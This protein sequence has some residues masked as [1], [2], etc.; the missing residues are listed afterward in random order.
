MRKKIWFW[1]AA[2]VFFSTASVICLLIMGSPPPDNV[3]AV[4]GRLAACPES[5]NC[6]CSQCDPRDRHF[7]KPL[8]LTEGPLDRQFRKLAKVVAELPRAIIVEQ[9]ETYLHAEFRSRLGF[10][11]DVEFLLNADD[12]L[13]HVRSASRTGWYDFG[14]NRK[15]IEQ[16]RRKWQ[17]N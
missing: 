4:A 12:Q 1:A 10:I 9:T 15:R 11:D 5:P 2:L 14:V 16:I 3:G 13:I 7:I 17:A 6:V 8:A